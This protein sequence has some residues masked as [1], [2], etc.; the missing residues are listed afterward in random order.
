MKH[1]TRW[2]A[3]ATIVAAVALPSWACKRGGGS[4]PTETSKLDAGAFDKAA[5][6]RAFGDCAYKS[7]READ[8]AI[9]ALEPAAARAATEKSPEARAAAREAWGRATQAWQVVELMQF[10]PAAMTG[11]P[12]GQD[13]RDGVYAWPLV[14]RCLVEQQLVAKVYETPALGTALVSTRSLASL[15]Y[16]LFYEQPDNACGAQAS[17]NTQG[18]WAALGAPEV[19]ARRLAYASAVAKDVTPRAKR[20]VEAWDPAR[21]NFL[22]QLENAGKPGSVFTSQQ[23]AFNAVSDALFYLDDMVKDMKVGKPAGIVACTSAVCPDPV[24]SPYSRLSKEHLRS[25]LLGFERIFRGCGANGEGLGFDDLLVAVGA[26]SVSERI[27]GSLAAARAALDGLGTRSLAQAIVED[28]A[29]V[30][31]LFDAIKQI[32]DTLK[33][34]FVTVLD[35][36]LPKRVE[37]DND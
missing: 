8:D 30:R 3:L 17:I 28:P 33:A 7:A 24:E 21:G 32:T 25:N 18:T 29:A 22:G 11:A 4:V 37:G 10:G 12:G 1:V 23:M 27:L 2:G 14:N 9:T 19:S 13:M 31:R 5:L 26:G 15:D 16:L 35:L 6:L 20:L 36:E 34:E